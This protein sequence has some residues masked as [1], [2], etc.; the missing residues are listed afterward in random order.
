MYWEEERALILSDLHFGKTGHFRKEGI[1]V[2]QRAYQED[3]Q[4]LFA[5]TQFFKPERLIVVGD[6]FHSH[7]NNELNL[8]SKWRNDMPHLTIDLVLGNHDVLGKRWYE[9]QHIHVHNDALEKGPFTFVHAPAD[10]KAVAT[11]RYYFSGH[12]HPGVRL[13]GTGKQ[14]LRFPCFYFTKSQCILP[15]FGSFTGL[16][17]Q[18]ASAGEKIFAIVGKEVMEIT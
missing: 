1:A 11:D 10:V 14:S 7:F 5:A 15:A 2:P 3:L 9:S 18:D 13:Q 17:I 6:F 8:F 12:L 16:A 4:R